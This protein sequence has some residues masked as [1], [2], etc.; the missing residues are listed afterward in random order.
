MPLFVG[1]GIAKAKAAKTNIEREQKNADYLQ[2]QLKSQ[3]EQEA[4][5]LNTYQS[6]IDYYKNTAIPNASLII[7]NASKAYLNG[8]ISYVEYVQSI[9]TASSIQLNYNEAISNYNQ[10]VINIQYL[11]NQ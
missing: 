7:K 4:E 10:T 1:S 2:Q 11:T 5:Q 3:F 8:D 9:E 6:L